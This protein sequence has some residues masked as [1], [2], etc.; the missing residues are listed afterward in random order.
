MERTLATLNDLM[1]LSKF[2]I[3]RILK[4]SQQDGRL[5]IDDRESTGR[6]DFKR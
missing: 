6:R 5:S 1:F 4:C 3:R 2:K